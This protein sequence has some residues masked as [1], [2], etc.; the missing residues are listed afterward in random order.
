MA[1]AALDAG[2]AP[3][4]DR[5]YFLRHGETDYNRRHIVQGWADIPLNFT[6][7]QQAKVAAQAL[8]DAGVTS[9][10]SSSAQRARRTAEIVSAAVGVPIHRLD[11]RLREKCFGE[12]EHSADPTPSVWTRQD[13]GAES[14]ADFAT[15]TVTGMNAALGEGLPLIVAHGGVRRVLL[16]G[17]GLDVT[18][19]AMGNAVPLELVR[20]NNSWR[21]NVLPSLPGEVPTWTP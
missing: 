4:V 12:Y 6:G 16:W 19:P 2:L 18:G 15:R 1:Q 14:Y 5:F 7:E 8:K 10:V 21:V 20:V 11:E 13:R 9:I 3:R 17:L